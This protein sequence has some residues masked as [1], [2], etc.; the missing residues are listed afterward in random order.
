MR[1]PLD[2]L[3]DKRSI[4][5]LKI[6]RVKNEELKELLWKEF[7]DYTVAIWKFIEEGFCKIEQIEEWHHE[8]YEANGKIWD[9]ES[10]I[11]KGK[12][13]ELGL[14]EVGRRAIMIRNIN[15]IRVAVKSKVVEMTGTG[16]KYIKIDHGSSETQKDY[17]SNQNLNKNLPPPVNPATLLR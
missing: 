9:L 1:Y 16:Y 6:E 4:I 10:D 14:D 12:E 3:L 2:E 11:R 5:L 7:S 17:L 13:N 8:L 15:G